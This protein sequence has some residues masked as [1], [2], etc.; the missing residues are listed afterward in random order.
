MSVK[1]GGNVFMTVLEWA[2]IAGISVQAVYKRKDIV[3]ESV[4]V[5][6]KM[7]NATAFPPVSKKR[8]PIRRRKI[9]KVLFEKKKVIKDSK[10]RKRKTQ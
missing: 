7:I 2:N 1:I 9:P 4:P 5:P 3:I 10:P 8:D 6:Q